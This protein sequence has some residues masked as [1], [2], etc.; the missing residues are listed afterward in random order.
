MQRQGSPRPSLGL[1]LPLEG[2]VHR[3]TLEG[4]FSVAARS[5]YGCKAQR[6]SLRA[7]FGTT[8]IRCSRHAL[9]WERNAQS[10]L[11]QY[12]ESARW[13]GSSQ[14]CGS[15][16]LSGPGIGRGAASPTIAARFYNN[17]RDSQRSKTASRTRASMDSMS[18][19]AGLPIRTS[20]KTPTLAVHSLGTRKTV[21]RM[22]P[23]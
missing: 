10:W 18:P 3:C 17:R 22:A 15:T 13:D 12:K 7:D 20:R 21:A 19:V 6:L 4:I 8:L 23:C 16:T 9:A 5:C 2:R 1:A 11:A 14:H